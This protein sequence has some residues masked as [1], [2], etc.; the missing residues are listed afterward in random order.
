[1]LLELNEIFGSTLTTNVFEVGSLV[2]ASVYTSFAVGLAQAKN[3]LE[4][5]DATPSR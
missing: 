4:P 1:M 3:F 2:V 5:A